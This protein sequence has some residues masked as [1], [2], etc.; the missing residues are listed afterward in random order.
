MAP[1]AEQVWIEGQ[2]NEEEISSGCGDFVCSGKQYRHYFSDGYA[3]QVFRNQPWQRNL[4]QSHPP[5]W[6]MWVSLTQEPQR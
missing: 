5:G 2:R 3:G 1:F 6:G 4:M